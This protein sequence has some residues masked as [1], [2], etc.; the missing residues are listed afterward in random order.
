MLIE[1]TLLGLDIDT[2]GYMIL[3]MFSH[4]PIQ[5]AILYFNRR[6]H[7]NTTSSLEAWLLTLDE[8]DIQYYL[9]VLL[10]L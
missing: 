3:C 8:N 2:I 4:L 7:Y 1:N 6:W 10:S 9:T 5:S